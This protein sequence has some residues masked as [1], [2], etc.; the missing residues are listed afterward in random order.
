MHRD[1][2]TTYA[3]GVLVFNLMVILWGAY[4]RATGSGAGCGS[5]WPLCNGEVVPRSPTT[6]TLIELTHR[7]TS[8]VALILVMALTVWCFRTHG[9]GHRARLAAVLALIFILLEATIGAG[10]VLLELVGTNDSGLRAVWIAVHLGNTFLLLAAL[11]LTAYWGRAQTGPIETGRIGDRILWQPPDRRLPRLALLALA[12][13]V[14]IGMSGAVAALGD[15]LFPASGSLGDELRQDQQVLLGASTSHLLKQLRVLHP[16]IAVVVSLVLLRLASAVRATSP[17]ASRAT[18]AGRPAP[19]TRRFANQLHLLV[20][21]QL[22]LGTFNIVLLAP[23]WIQL[24]HLLL[25]DLLWIAL[26]LTCAAALC[27]VPAATVPTET[28]SAKPTH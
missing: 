27:E 2:F 8:G 19:Q 11:T 25:A 14:L 21:V 5:N 16:L 24:V 3:W 13:T 15:T 22:A 12:G 6:E 26:V 10:V 23:V 1:R 17:G 18:S 9:R 4:V 28:V 20:F 7:L